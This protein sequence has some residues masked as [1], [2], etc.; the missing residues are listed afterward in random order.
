[1]PGLPCPPSLQALRKR[2]RLREIIQRT[3]VTPEHLWVLARQVDPSLKFV[4][5]V[6]KPEYT[7]AELEERVQFCFDMLNEPPEW[8]RGIVWVD[9]SSVPLDPQPQKVIGH[10]GKETL[11]TDPRKITDKRKVPHIHYML[12]VCWATGLVKMD[13]LSYTK[14]YN[15]PVQ[16]YVSAAA[17]P[18]AP[19]RPPGPAACGLA[20]SSCVCTAA[21]HCR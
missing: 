17:P 4:K 8:L 2:P 13:I 5:P 14:G 1:M 6:L 7:K 11:L 21:A 9:E 15:D 18:A 12:A 10:K 20:C 19:P 16:Y 3:G